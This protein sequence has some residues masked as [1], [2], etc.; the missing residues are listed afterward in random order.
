M[1]TEPYKSARTV[2]WTVDN[3]SSHRGWTAADRLSTAWPNT[4]MVHTPV[5]AS[6]LN[7]IE[8]YF[9]IL[10]RKAL[11]GESFTNLDTLAHR[12]LAFQTRYNQTAKPFSWHY[13][14]T[15]LNAHLAR[16]DQPAA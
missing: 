1:E 12:I 7:Q 10:S 11:A 13:T 8:I 14:R 2:Y 3:G 9:S 15:D 6:W 16:L 5:H 4:V